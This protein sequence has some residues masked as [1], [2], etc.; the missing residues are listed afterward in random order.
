MT[1]SIAARR[2]PVPP[3]FGIGWKEL[4]GHV[5]QVLVSAPSVSANDYAGFIVKDIDS[6]LLKAFQ[7]QTRAR[8]EKAELFIPFSCTNAQPHLVYHHVHFDGVVCLERTF[9]SQ[10]I[11]FSRQWPSV[12]ISTVGG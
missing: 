5:V 9:T 12:F 10:D 3:Q 1:C 6:L 4:L 8:G 7:S 11:K 2:E